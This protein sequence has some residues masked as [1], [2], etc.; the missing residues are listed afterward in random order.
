MPL[1]DA[2][3]LVPLLLSKLLCNVKIV[4]GGLDTPEEQGRCGGG[5]HHDNT[6]GV[7]EGNVTAQ[8]KGM[9]NGMVIFSMNSC[10]DNMLQFPEGAM[11]TP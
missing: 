7:I 4:D 6:D 10:C 8:A 3:Y 1:P 5:S 2:K 9:R 11:K